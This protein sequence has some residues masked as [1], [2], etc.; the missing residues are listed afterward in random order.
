LF[1]HA[2]ELTAQLLGHF[3]LKEL[4][5]VGKVQSKMAVAEDLQFSLQGVPPL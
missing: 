5:P 4:F 2:L 1:D 3:G